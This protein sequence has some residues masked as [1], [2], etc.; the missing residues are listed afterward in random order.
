MESALDRF[1]LSNGNAGGG[2]RLANTPR[3]GYNVGA[4]YRSNMGL[5]GNMEIVG[6]SRQFD[7]NNHDE[8]RS[9]FNVVN[10]SVGYTYR[11]WTIT[12]WG[13]NLFDER[14]E[15]RVFFFGNEDPDYVPT[16]YESRADPRQVGVTAA[17][18]F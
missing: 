2:R 5:F 11:D 1:V 10:A 8:A 16:R 4:R 15:K 14:Y 17:Y 7:S 6:R 13:R 12:L 18:R 3:H 9:A